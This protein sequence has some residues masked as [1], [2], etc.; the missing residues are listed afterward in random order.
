M[1]K[2]IYE[3]N[4]HWTGNYPL[5]CFSKRLIYVKT[6]FFFCLIECNVVRINIFTLELCLKLVI[7]N[8][9]TSFWFF[10]LWSQEL[11]LRLNET[12]KTSTEQ[13][14]IPWKC[15][16][17]SL[18][19]IKRSSFFNWIGSSRNKSFFLDFNLKVFVPFLSLV[20]KHRI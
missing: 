13:L 12:Y 17:N 15:Y 11:F 18:T 20:K 1:T 7:R 2:N 4:Q 9:K 3:I 8:G 5:K 10:W 6:S 14:T 19:Y 16:L